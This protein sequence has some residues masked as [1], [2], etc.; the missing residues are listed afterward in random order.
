MAIYTISDLNNRQM[1]TIDSIKRALRMASENDITLRDSRPLMAML[2]RMEE[3]SPRLA[4][5]ILTRKT[6]LSSYGWVIKS[7]Q[8][9]KEKA[10]EVQQRLKKIINFIL[11]ECVRTPLYGAFA[12]ELEWVLMPSPM[13]YFQPRAKRL[14]H[15]T[16][17]EKDFKTLYILETKSDGYGF[18]RQD[19]ES[20]ENHSSYYIY[21]TDELFKQGG[22]LRSIIFHEVLRNDT[23]QEW[24]NYNKKLKGL[25]QALAPDNEKADAADGLRNFLTN[26]F[27]VTSKEVEF[28]LNDLSSGKS[29]E[30]FPAFLDYLNKEIQ[31]AILGQANTVELPNIG[32]SRA[33][34][35][36]LDLIRQDIL[37]ADMN[38]VKTLIDDQLL[39]AD[40]R[41]NVEKTAQESAFEF[42]FIEDQQDNHETFARVLE[43]LMRSGVP[44]SK[45][46]V[47]A[48]LNLN[49]PADASDALT[50]TMNDTVFV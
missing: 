43:S 30:S 50:R 17:I 49:P 13:S 33:A 31:I 2:N 32:G 16:E 11:N 21:E 29:L 18:T 10:T 41:W 38:R 40:Y 37:F 24:A 23:I 27:A 7:K 12:L 3:V 42:E 35:Q 39:L 14:F 45:S 46:E 34:V 47:Y 19:I 1:P 44:L 4:G 26:N 20:I 8:G 22:I 9:N 6:G 15:P 36:V 28:K 48:K 5:A 25:I